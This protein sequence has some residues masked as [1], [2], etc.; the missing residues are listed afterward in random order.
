[1]R[2]ISGIELSG[3]KIYEILAVNGPEFKI[4]IFPSEEDEE[5]KIDFYN[6][7]FH[8]K[9]YLSYSEVVKL[10]GKHSIFGMVELFEQSGEC[11]DW[12]SRENC[13]YT[14][15]VLNKEKKF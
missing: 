9:S 8:V 5:N 7:R 4:I 10:N 11:P 1:M 3:D 15:I 2:I 14:Y 6:D 13:H 12:Y